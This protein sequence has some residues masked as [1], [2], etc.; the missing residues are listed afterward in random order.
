M[1]A[2]GVAWAYAPRRLTLDASLL[3]AAVDAGAEVRQGFSVEEILFEGETVIGVRGRANGGQP[4]E[5]RGTVIVGADGRNSRLARAV[6]APAY[7]E[8]PVLLCWYFSYW[9]G[10]Q[11]EPFE[12]YVRSSDKRVILAFRTN[13][14]LYAIF[15]AAP[16]EELAS[17]RAGIE[18]N[19]L[20]TLDLAPD[21]AERVS[22]GKRVERF[23]GASD[24]PNFYRKPYGP[25]WALVGDAGLHKDPHMALGICDALRDVEYLSEAI[26]TGLQ[27][28][29]SMEEA[30]AQY[31][32]R[33]NEASRQDYE[34]NISAAR[35]TPAPPQ[36]L[37]LRAALRDNPEGATNFL[38]ARFGLMDP[39]E[40]FN[41]E[42][43][44]RLMAAGHK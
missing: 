19:F 6:S 7:N 1:E 39:R 27:G 30:L 23:Y 25:G 26:G 21:F 8:V 41:P 15:V 16:I 32:V 44:E 17:F 33:R 4:V 29:S 31:E 22:A 34:D 11:A 14:D 37:S 2:E 35:F 18:A 36:V 5:E 9:A 10:V 3:D 42:N 20:K 12:M 13:D 43:L 38:K 40:F 24:L 28:G